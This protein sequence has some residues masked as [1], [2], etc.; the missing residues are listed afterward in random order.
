MD[1]AGVCGGRAVF[2][3]LAIIVMAHEGAA[4]VGPMIFTLG[5]W[6][7]VVGGG[8]L[9]T[10]SEVRKLLRQTAEAVRQSPRSAG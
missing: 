2:S 6:L 8:W 3:A 1:A 5:I 7:L 9:G 4:A 10:R